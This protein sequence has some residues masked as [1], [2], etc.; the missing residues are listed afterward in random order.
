MAEIITPVIIYFTT[1][2]LSS[3]K[4]LELITYRSWNNSA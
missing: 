4:D 3:M 2:R 1:N